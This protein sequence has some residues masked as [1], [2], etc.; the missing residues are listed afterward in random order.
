VAAVCGAICAAAN[1]SAAPVTI[2]RP[3]DWTLSRLGS[4]GLDIPLAREP[5]GRSVGYALPPDAQQGPQRWYLIHLHFGVD[6]AKSSGSGFAYVSGLTDRRAAAQVQFHLTSVGQG[7]KARIAWES[8]DLIHGQVKHVTSSRH[9]EVDFTNYLQLAGVQPGRNTLKFKLER[10]DGIKVRRLHVFADSGLVFTE[11]SPPILAVRARVGPEEVHV[12][13]GF[14]VEFDLR[15]AGDYAA[16][17]VSAGLRPSRSGVGLVGTPL[18]QFG[19]VPAGGTVHGQLPLLARREGKYGVT[20]DASGGANL[21]GARLHVEVLPAA[22][23][24]GWAAGRWVLGGLL[25]T[26]GFAALAS[27]RRKNRTP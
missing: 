24:G 2:D 11:R 16:R 12:G 14:N 8:L 18:V 9:V 4:G 15:N 13:D 27:T 26:A 6:F 22:A 23:G 19:R 5:A 21:A 10:L 3:G 20:I 7:R 1:T 17:H 25:V